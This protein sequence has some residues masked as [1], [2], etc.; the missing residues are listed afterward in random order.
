MT[1]QSTKSGARRS[2]T[3]SPKLDN[4]STSTLFG[5]LAQC[6]FNIYLIVT[7]IADIQK[8]YLLAWHHLS[9]HISRAEVK[10][11]YLDL[12][13]TDSK[14]IVESLHIDTCVPLNMKVPSERIEL[15]QILFRVSRQEAGRT[16]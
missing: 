15:A 8:V 2:A 13:A 4:T 6:A 9:A 14:D 12:L 11:S 10:A 5:S 3:C 16:S 7:T 1:C